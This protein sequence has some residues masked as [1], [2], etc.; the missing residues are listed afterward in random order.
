M[1]LKINDIYIYE[2]D[3]TK[4]KLKVKI[5][6]IGFNYIECDVIEDIRNSGVGGHIGILLSSFKKY[7]KKISFKCL[8]DE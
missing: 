7:S 6:K 5:N 8:P 1:E 4:L 3:K 2:N